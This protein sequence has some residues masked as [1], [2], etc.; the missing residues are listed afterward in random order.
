MAFGKSFRPTLPMKKEVNR[1]AIGL[2]FYLLFIILCTVTE[3]VYVLI[4]YAVQN[5]G[6]ISYEKLT[7]VTDQV[8]QSGIS[9]LVSASVGMLLLWL[10]YRK[11]EK[12]P[13]FAAQKAMTGRTFWESLCVL[14]SVQVVFTAAAYVLERVANLF[15]LSLMGEI[16]SASAESKTISMFLYASFLGP[17]SEEIIF[18]GLVL[19][20]LQKYGK[21]L[22]IIVSAVLFGAYHGNFVQG[23][24]AMCIGLL[25]G[26]VATEYSLIWSIVLHIVNNAVFGDLLN[27]VLASFSQEVQSYI[28]LVSNGVFFLAACVILWRKRHDIRAYMVQ[29]KTHGYGA[30]FSSIGVI[31]LF[32]LLLFEACMGLQKTS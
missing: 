24:F 25:L 26:F 15:G 12:P 9:Y 11:I 5:G 21:V 1:L 10:F 22:A 2:I 13:L 4:S 19:K 23:I 32:C 16:S 6:N 30:V 18:R 17:V 20:S 8:S 7:E 29:N 31:V 3:Q 27:Y 14:M 28:V